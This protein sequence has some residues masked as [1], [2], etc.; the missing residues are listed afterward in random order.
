MAEY[1]ARFEVTGTP[2]GI[3]WN[4]LTELT[5]RQS[6]LFGADPSGLPGVIAQPTGLADMELVEV[7]LGPLPDPAGSVQRMTT[8][9]RA[10]PAGTQAADLWWIEDD[11][12][13]AQDYY[14]NGALPC[15]AHLSLLSGINVNQPIIRVAGDALAHFA[16][17]FPATEVEAV[18]RYRPRYFDPTNAS[19]TLFS[20]QQGMLFVN[21][22]ADPAQSPADLTTWLRAIERGMNNTG[23]SVLLGSGERLNLCSFTAVDPR[24]IVWIAPGDIGVGASQI[25]PQVSANTGAAYL[26]HPAAFWAND[27]AAVARSWEAITVNASTIDTYAGSVVIAEITQ[28]LIGSRWLFV[29]DGAPIVVVIRHGVVDLRR[30]KQIWQQLIVPLIM[31]Q[32]QQR[33]PIFWEDYISGGNRL[34]RPLGILQDLS[35]LQYAHFLEPLGGGEASASTIFE[36]AE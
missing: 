30:P 14:A 32:G 21:T 3:H 16:G 23:G 4:Q 26:N 35:R 36:Q 17:G 20:L 27:R 29:I 28:Q 2:S 19:R 33:G 25:P 13:P 31:A 18:L 11:V 24:G 1:S 9:G 10:L 7:T 15:T 5:V 6:L 12:V 34:L 8:G 22:L